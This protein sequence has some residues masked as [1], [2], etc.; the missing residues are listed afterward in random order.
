MQRFKTS[1]FLT[2]KPESTELYILLVILVAIHLYCVAA[3]DENL[4]HFSFQENDFKY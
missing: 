2:D 1:V 3:A 4:S